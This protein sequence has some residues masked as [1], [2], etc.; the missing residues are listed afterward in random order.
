MEK[1]KIPKI[2]LIYNKSEDLD[3]LAKSGK[4]D[5]ELLLKSYKEVE[6]AIENNLPKIEL[7]DVFNLSLMIEIKIKNYNNLLNKVLQIYAKDEDFDECT[8]IQ[9]LISKN[10]KKI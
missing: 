10:E 7:F 1:R 6:Y 5:K 4:M 9:S 3:E 2:E 8:K